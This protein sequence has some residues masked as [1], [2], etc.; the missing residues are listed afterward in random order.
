MKEFYATLGTAHGGLGYVRIEAETELKARELIYACLEGRWC[1][2][3]RDLESL[4]VLDRHHKASIYRNVRG[5]VVFVNKS[6][7]PCILETITKGVILVSSQ[8]PT[9]KHK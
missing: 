2:T 7:P 3:Y 1:T 8:N 6:M 5:K 4:H 9:Q